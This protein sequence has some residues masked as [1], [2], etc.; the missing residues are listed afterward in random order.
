[1]TRK[2][3][4][5]HDWV[6]E[7]DIRG[8]F[9]NLDHNLLFKALR[10]H[11]NEKWILLYVGRWL[12]TP[13]QS[14]DGTLVS[15]DKGTPQGGPLSPLLSNLFLHY[16]LDSWLV[17]SHPQVPFCRYADDGILH[18]DSLAHANQL[19]YMMRII[20]RR[21][22]YQIAT[23]GES[24]SAAEALAMDIVNHE[25]APRHCLRFGR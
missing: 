21:K 24:F 16:A 15:R 2:R 23:T 14:Q 6:L 3:C 17:R 11:T 25:E 5:E 20:P 22:L 18:C 4:W 13:M 19:R 7:Y 9:D 12:T 8:L 1:M 10:W